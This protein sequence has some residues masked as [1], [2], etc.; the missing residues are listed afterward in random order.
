[1]PNE[2]SYTDP[3]GNRYSWADTSNAFN[4]VPS[5][6]EV[7]YFLLFGSSCY[8]ALTSL[9]FTTTNAGVKSLMAFLLTVANY[10][11]LIGLLYYVAK[12]VKVFIN[13]LLKRR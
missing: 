11:I 1:M 6:A 3:K 7:I 12:L 10:A 5:S 9:L 8:L 4:S 13:I 2:T